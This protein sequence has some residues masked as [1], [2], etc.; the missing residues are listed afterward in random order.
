MSGLHFDRQDFG[1][2]FI[3]LVFGIIL[4]AKGVVFLVEGQPS[5]TLLGSIL[6]IVGIASLP[7]YL[8]WVI[9]VCHIV[10]GIMIALGAFFKIST[11]LFGTFLLLE[12]AFKYKMGGNLIREVANLVMLAAVM[13]GFVFIGS[14]TYT[15]QKQ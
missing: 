9:A 7:L 3:R 6:S 4:A 2:L 13:Y 11:F 12:A 15:I 10:C 8:G 5:L 1:K 14:G